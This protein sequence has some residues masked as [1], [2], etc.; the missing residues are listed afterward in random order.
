MHKR[1][2]MKDEICKLL[3]IADRTYYKWKL[4]KRPI[5]Q[6]LHMFNQEDLKRYLEDPEISKYDLIKGS[7]SL[8]YIDLIIITGILTKLEI[9]IKDFQLTK[10]RT[11]IKFYRTLRDMPNEIDD[12]S[13]YLKH[14]KMEW[15][16]AVNNIML[17]TSFDEIIVFY[18]TYLSKKEIEVMRNKKEYILPPLK[19]MRK[20]NTHQDD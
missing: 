2:R 4:E 3:K 5:I 9:Y 7:N 16:E 19:A 17:W 10:E 12:Y 13:K 6:F 11:L 20:Y 8:S 1:H 15:G 18:E 14:Y